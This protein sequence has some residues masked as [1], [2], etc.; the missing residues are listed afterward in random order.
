MSDERSA[1]GAIAPARFV[2]AVC[3]R[4]AEQLERT[5]RNA[6]RAWFANDIDR[7]GQ[8]DGAQAEMSAPVSVAGTAAGFLRDTVENLVRDSVLAGTPGF[9][10]HLA[11]PADPDRRVIGAD[12]GGAV[13]V[14]LAGVPEQILPVLR[15]LAALGPFR[16]I[17]LKQTQ[18]HVM[19]NSSRSP[20]TMTTGAS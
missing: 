5:R 13:G 19:P 10:H 7:R 8:R 9:L 18:T 6:L 20:R 17:V 3:G 14:G 15:Q 11:A 2:G 12:V 4:R 1:C 16:M